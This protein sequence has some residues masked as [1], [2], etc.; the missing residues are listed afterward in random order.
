MQFNNTPESSLSPL[1]AEGRGEVINKFTVPSPDL[2]PTGVEGKF[3][4]D[5]GSYGQDISDA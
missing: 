3:H 2:S 4:N 5:D 1:K